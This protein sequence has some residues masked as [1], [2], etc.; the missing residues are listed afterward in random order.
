MPQD[1]DSGTLA[2]EYG[3]ETA[4]EIAAKI[5]ATS[6]SDS[7]NEFAHKG[8]LITIRSAHQATTSVG[9]TYNMLE[10]IDSVVAAF[11]NQDGGYD[12]YEM[13]PALY[14]IRMRDSKNEGKVGL[15]TRSTF[16][17]IGQPIATV[18]IN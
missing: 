16:R 9:V 2:N 13:S 11:E 8:R 14:R 6:V 18:W 4:R 15:V 17:E 10:R 3:H 12:L 1:A 5:G 7:S